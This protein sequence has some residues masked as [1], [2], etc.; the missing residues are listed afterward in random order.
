MRAPIKIAGQDV[1]LT[2]ALGIAIW[3]QK[4]AT[5]ADLL[6]DAE[7][8]MYRAKRSGA[9]RVETFRAGD[10]QRGRQPRCRR[11]RIANRARPA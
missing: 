1:V 4:I 8:A 7:V 5:A 9:D 11:E 10:A 3:D 6:K 2:A